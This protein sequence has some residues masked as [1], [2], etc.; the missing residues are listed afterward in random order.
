[1][2]T[3]SLKEGK[4]VFIDRCNLDREQRSEFVKLGGPGIEVHA[5]VLELPA[6][7][8]I[9]RSVKR[10][11]HEGNLQ[12]GRAAAVVNRM[13][14]SKELPKVNEGFSRVMFC[15]NDADVENAVNT[16]SKLGPMDTLPSGCFG[17]KKPHTKSQPGI[18]KFCKKVNALPGSSS[19]NEATN[20]MRKANDETENFRL[21]YADI[22][23]TLAFPSISTADFQF[24]L[25][26]A[27]DIIVEKAEEF[28]PKVGT[29]RL[30]LVDLS[31]G[32]KILSLV[33]AKASQKNIDSERFFTFVGDKTKLRSE[34][35]LHCN[36]IANATNW[37][38]KHGGGGVNAAIFKAAG[39][40]LETATRVL[41]NTLLPGIAVVVPLPS[42]CPLHNAEGITHVIHVLGPNM[43]PNRP[44]NLN[45]DYTKGC[46]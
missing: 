25:E 36:V 40:D 24:D 44:D 9:S 35:G 19:S 23:H 5:V 14:Q 11:G 7:V 26:K 3:S 4:S 33:K 22:V 10:T 30:V 15:Y 17:E 45:N 34:G 8:C 29:A 12:G 46:I 31:H 2:A 27:S 41:A 38:L 6:Q 13:L 37:R 32:S 1:M 39:P 18:M 42:T 16:Y 20:A 21:G 43:N 28:L